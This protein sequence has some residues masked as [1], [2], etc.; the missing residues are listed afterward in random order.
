MELHDQ[1][2]LVTGATS[3]IGEKVAARLAEERAEVIVSG[4]HPQRGAAVV[5]MILDK[6]GRAR[7]VQ[8][9]LTVLDDVRRLAGEAVDAQI[10]VNVAGIYSFAPTLDQDVD[11]F[12]AM[13]STN[14]RGPF[15]L[16]AALVPG[17]I[18]RGG[19]SIVNIT[20]A[21]AEVGVPGS[22]AY[23]ASKAAL[24][25]L[26]R[27]WAAEFGPSGIRVNSV[28]PGPVRTD[29]A[30]SSLGGDELLNQIAS[31]LPLGR[32]SEPEEIAEVVAFLVSP[33]AASVTGHTLAAD[34]GMT[35]V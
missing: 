4:R 12:E 27:T 32:P 23:A 34:G 9:D 17:M 6:G 7:F 16:T 25:S 28:S 2:A 20:T 10:L 21:G 22:A 24:A 15:F 18:A 35:I 11:S 26:T 19:G 13:F 29:H 31:G 33:R 1:I 8:A 5:E 30:L 3:G 14:V